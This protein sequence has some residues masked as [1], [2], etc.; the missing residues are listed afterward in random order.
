MALDI[1]GAAD[2]SLPSRERGL[3]C[4]YQLDKHTDLQV[5]PFAGA[6]IEIFDNPF[7]LW[8]PKKVA[9]FAGAWIEILQIKGIVIVPLVAPFAGA[10]IEILYEV[11]EKLID[12]TSL[13]S[14]ERGLKYKP[15]TNTGNGIRRSLRGSVD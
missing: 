13:P 5:A 12:L 2:W 8:N 11:I 6:W 10:W 14:R 9:P 7:T 1:I 4:L 3:K 15:K